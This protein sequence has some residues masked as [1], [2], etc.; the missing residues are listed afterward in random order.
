MRSR[1][2]SSICPYCAVGC[3]LVVEVEDGI[4]ARV[5]GDEDHPANLGKLCRK[6]VLLPGMLRTPDR[7]LHPLVRMDTSDPFRR[8]GWDE[9]I[10][11]IAQKIRRVIDRHGADAVAFY[12][13]GQ[14]P[15]EDYYVLG[16]LAKA[17]IGTNNQDTNSRL[18]MTSAAAAY[19]LAFGRDGAPCSHS[20]IDH[21]TCFLILGANME[22]C[23]P[24]LFQRIKARKQLAPEKVT[25]IVVDPRRTKTA[26]IADI[27]LPVRP[28]ADVALLN[29][30]LH[31]IVEEDLVD[32]AFVEAHTEG[33]E[34]VADL[35]LRDYSPESVAGLCGVEAS[36]IRAAARAYG[37]ASA[38]LSLWAMGANQS[39]AGVD[40]N[41]ALI[42]LALATGNIG[43]PGAG[44]FSLTGQPNAVG[45]RDA[46]GLSHS[47]PGHRLIADPEHRAEMEIFWGVPPGRIS[48]QP[49]LTAVEMFDAMA[50]GKVKVLWVLCT[51]PLASMPNLGRVKQ[52]VERAE[53]VVV[54]DAYHPTETTRFAH[55]VLPAAQWSERE[56]TMT[57]GERRICLLEKAGDPPG[58][59]LPDWE[60]LCRFARRMGYGYAFAYRNVEEIF[61]ELGSST[62]G[63]DCDFK[64]LTYDRLRGT[65]GLQ[66]PV[67]DEG[68]PGTE[69]LYTDGHFHTGSGRARFH[70]LAYRPPAESTDP[71]YP[72]VLL[73]GRVKD[74]WHTRTR[75]GKIPKLDRS[76]P[77]PYVEINPQDAAELGLQEGSL[78][79]ISSRRGTA[80]L[81]AKLSG[82]VR[83]G[84][85][86]VPFHWGEL[87]GA[88][89]VV[90]EL[91]SPCFDPIS[92]EPEL[93]Y[94]AVQLT[95][96]AA[97]VPATAAAS[98]W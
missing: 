35:V 77:Q 93:K 71:N 31:V 55:V 8:V 28:G 12:G 62:A 46:G 20:D 66:W 80:R 49:G 6:G 98:T 17:F 83:R 78:V 70:A 65:G 56:G 25:V 4:A 60:I 23:H 43:K 1:T 92:K 51:N 68:A 73:T 64:G 84:E 14:L 85:V 37:E 82:D 32:H 10:G 30:M 24:V 3:G 19:S 5:R 94:C 96:V 11:F 75:T 47:L 79:E 7:A 53:L 81:P 13:S 72:F 2:I 52:A 88:D 33:F 9:A 76:C 15:N 36:L 45:G 41:L 26:S 39:T 38:S 86:F 87:W 54:Q 69:R 63:R 61:A 21:A 34:A 58:E 16:K 59:A 22:A 89:R 40:K 74:Q 44:P 48:P 91:T 95:P 42:N 90:N 18:C 97:A 27:Y 50:E 57:N 67:P 29:A